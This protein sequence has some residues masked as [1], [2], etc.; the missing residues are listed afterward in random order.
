LLEKTWN[1]KVKKNCLW[2]V[3]EIK[4]QPAATMSKIPWL[5]VLETME[6]RVGNLKNWEVKL[7]HS[8]LN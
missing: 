5:F 4:T 3:E 2:I 8:P 1:V 7:F 6:T